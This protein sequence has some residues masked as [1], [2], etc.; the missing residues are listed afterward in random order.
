MR[1]ETSLFTPNINFQ[2]SL[3][4][5]TAQINVS[6]LGTPTTHAIAGVTVFRLVPAA[7][8]WFDGTDWWNDASYRQHPLCFRNNTWHHVE[9]YVAMNSISGG[10][11]QANGILKY[12]VDGNLVINRANTYLRTAQ[13][14]HTEIQ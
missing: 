10:I 1:V 12:W 9:F 6:L 7:T 11:P 3:R 4:L 13:L 5:N 14:C 2:D 8:S